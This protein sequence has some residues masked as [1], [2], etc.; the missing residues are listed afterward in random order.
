MN[1]IS[2]CAKLVID[3]NLYSKLPSKTPENYYDDLING[4]KKFLNLP[5]IEKVTKGDTVEL[6]KAPHRNGFAIG[7]KY[8]NSKTGE[9]YN[10]GVFTNKK[11][12]TITPS[13]LIYNTKVCIIAKSGIKMGFFENVPKAFKRAVEELMKKYS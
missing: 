10:S 6:F 5:L 3:K 2:F 11:E 4:Y 7:I 1:N 13:E 12:A 9:V 8:T